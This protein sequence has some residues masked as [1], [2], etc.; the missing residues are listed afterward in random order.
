VPLPG[1]FGILERRLPQ[2]I[3]VQSALLSQSPLRNPAELPN[4]QGEAAVY[5]QITASLASH[6]IV[7]NSY[8]TYTTF[9]FRVLC[10]FNN[11]LTMRLGSYPRSEAE[12][13][14]CAIKQS[15]PSVQTN[16]S[17]PISLYLNSTGTARFFLG[18][19]TTSACCSAA[20]LC[21]KK[22]SWS[23]AQIFVANFL[24]RNFVQTAAI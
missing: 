20:P 11:T 17:L 14:L 21:Q 1:K 15:P 18:S 16:H 23:N 4:F 2:F 6:H 3:K 7:E 13:R 8:H 24:A 5:E 9:Y 12:A 22:R 10:T 19:V